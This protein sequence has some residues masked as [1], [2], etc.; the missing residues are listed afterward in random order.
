MQFVCGGLANVNIRAFVIFCAVRDDA[1]L[2]P[3][4]LVQGRGVHIFTVQMNVFP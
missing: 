1:A 4:A 3:G 2:M